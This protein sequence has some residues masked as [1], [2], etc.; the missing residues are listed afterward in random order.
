MFSGGAPADFFAAGAALITE[1]G[2]EGAPVVV[3]A[4]VGGA[5]KDGKRKGEVPCGVGKATCGQEQQQ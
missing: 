3:D 1:L 2:V 4:G 5:D